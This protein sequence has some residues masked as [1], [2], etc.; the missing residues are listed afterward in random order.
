MEK[1]ISRFNGKLGAY[2]LSFTD[3][4]ESLK[5]TSQMPGDRLSQWRAYSGGGRGISLG[6]DYEALLVNSDRITRHGSGTLAYVLDC[7]YDQQ[8]KQMITRRAARP[9]EDRYMQ[10]ERLL[11]ESVLSKGPN[12]KPPD[13]ND[14]IWAVI[15]SM[16]RELLTEWTINAPIFKNPAFF[17]EKEW[18]IVILAS[19]DHAPE[20]DLSGKEEIS[21]KFRSGVVGVTPYVEFPLRLGTPESPLRRVVVGPTPHME[22]AARG[23]E[24]FLEDKGIRLRTAD[25]PNGVEVVPSKIPYR[26]W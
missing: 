14:E 4:A 26:N 8:D 21:V 5:K 3:D 12:S 13:E 15:P 16:V 2:V 19:R 10:H 1:T 25:S 20:D 23:V 7:V 6:F 9:I 17:E 22:Q 18:R 24:M 11:I